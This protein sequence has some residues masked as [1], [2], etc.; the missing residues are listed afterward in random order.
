MAKE[1]AKF[2]KSASSDLYYKIKYLNK[3]LLD[4]QNKIPIDLLLKDEKLFNSNFKY[5]LFNN[6][7]NHPRV[8]KYLNNHLNGLYLFNNFTPKEWI[9]TFKKIIQDNKIDT[10]HFFRYQALNIDKFHTT[11]KNFCEEVNALPFN[12]NEIANFYKLYQ[13]G[14]IV[15]PGEQ[16]ENT[17]AI[18]NALAEETQSIVL[19][20][21]ESIKN[22]INTYTSYK[23]KRQPCS[24][25][26]AFY[27]KMQIFDTNLSDISPANILIIT[28][29][30]P[31]SYEIEKQQFLMDANGKSFKNY[32]QRFA[33]RTGYTYVIS[34]MSFCE[35]KGDGKKQVK[36]CK[37][38]IDELIKS[39]DPQYI[40]VLGAK[41]KS[42]LEIK[43]A[44]SKVHAQA[45]GKYFVMGAISDLE[46]KDGHI[47][48]EY[49][50]SELE[51]L[52]TANF[53]SSAPVDAIPQQNTNVSQQPQVRINQQVQNSN[54][55]P[56][57]TLFN[58]DTVGE[59]LLYTFI[60]PD[61]EKKFQ[62]V[63]RTYPVY[64][65]KGD[66]GTCNYID[67][68]MDA[69]INLTLSQKKELSTLLTQK[70]QRLLQC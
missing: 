40:V 7:Q 29:L 37:S 32:L 52:L 61:G 25:C 43:G 34:S 20:K 27:S 35:L 66:F 10:L 18:K 57:D 56:I 11:L 65:K 5:R 24:Q 68:N 3:Y 13:N 12:S 31:T 45:T 46:K 15:L 67:T 48:L 8:I 41:V 9:E 70:M 60:S 16:V 30:A 64:Y 51:K 54:I 14:L 4:T 22:L 2:E 23:N 44:M 50:F 38:F 55:L 59:K 58:I 21:S 53:R 36:N 17:E 39:F 6:L 28:D 19:P 26:P 63:D 33:D 69:V 42:A 47:K 1:K 62:L 49:A